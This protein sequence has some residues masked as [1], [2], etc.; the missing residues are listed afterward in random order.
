[1]Y[2]SLSIMKY[3]NKL[4]HNANKKLKDKI[5]DFKQKLYPTQKKITFLIMI[6]SSRLGSNCYAN[7]QLTIA[8]YKIFYYPFPF[9]ISK[10]NRYFYLSPSSS[11]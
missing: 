1:M 9:F 6:S 4:L 7:I 8:C 2:D 5:T 3:Q 10:L 11:F